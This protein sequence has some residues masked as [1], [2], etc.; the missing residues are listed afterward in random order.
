MNERAVN[1][2]AQAIVVCIA[3]DV[4]KTPLGGAM[5]PVPYTITSKLDVAVDTAPKVN[6]GGLPAF[7]MASRL[8]TVKGDEKGVGGGILSGVNLG[9]CRPIEHSGT[10]RAHEQFIV[11]HNDLFHMNCA[12]PD[13]VGN[14]YGRIVYIGVGGVLPTRETLYKEE[15]ITADQDGKTVVE[16]KE[17]TRDPR[18][19][20]ITETRQRTT[21]DP[22]TGRVETAELSVTRDPATGASTYEATSGSFDPST[23]NY[24][25]NQQ[26][27][28]VTG[29]GG[30][31]MPGGG[32]LGS[33]GSVLGSDQIGQVQPNGQVYLGDGV[34][35]D[36]NASTL[37]DPGIGQGDLS[38]DLSGL[39]SDPEYQAALAEQAQTQAELDAINEELYWE[40]AETAADLAG[41]VDPTP[42]S[43]SVAAGLALRRG[44]YL[45]AGLNLLSWV[46][47]LGDAIAKPIKGVRASAR[48]ARLMEKLRTLTAKL[49]KI[50][51]ALNRAK[52]RLKKRLNKT[53]DAPPPEKPPAPGPGGHVPKAKPPLKKPVRRHDPCKTK[54]NDPTKE[55]NSMLDPDVDVDADLA[56]ISKG[57]FVKNGDEIVVNG[58]TYGYHADTGT[59]FPMSGP[60]VVDMDRAQHQ[61]LKQ[62]N[63]QSFE[64]AMKFASN[65]PGLDGDKITQVLD[66]WKKCK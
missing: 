54:G 16:R 5:V 43:D 35:G 14:T 6:Y 60:G 55:K 59:T 25:F 48:V 28:S 3:P 39:S 65:F 63:S 33:T 41:L 62:L 24:S 53:P 1:K 2:D 47:Y 64:N 22:A 58:R 10:V 7:T 52:D 36:P 37:S 66:L 9:Y 4:C 44:D 40:G 15:K 38:E 42:S 29:A 31:S 27:G 11:R 18:T 8:P 23:N 45:G 32:E 49:D 12:G 20:E 56:K 34:Y 21:I 26:T 46:P 19:G 13:G 30:P 51:D 61:L 17:I 57:E 50:K